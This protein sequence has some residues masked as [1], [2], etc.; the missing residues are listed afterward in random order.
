MDLNSRI[1]L[2]DGNKIPRLGL[3]TW[4]TP[5]G[6]QAENAVSWALEAGYRLVDTAAIYHNEE[7][8]GKAVRESGIPREDVFVTT[9]LWNSDHDAP[10]KA[11]DSSLSR[12]GLEY[13]DLYLMHWPVEGVRNKTWKAMQSLLD[14][15]VCR[16][17][18][19]SNFTVRH[20]VELVEQTGVVPVVNQV[21]FSPFLY[22]RELLDYCKSN[23]IIVEAYSP[24]ARGSRMGDSALTEFTE[25]YGKTPAQILIRWALQHDLV[26]IPK[27]THRERI[28]EN[29]KVFDFSLSQEDMNKLDWLNENYR[30]CWDPSQIP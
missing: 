19:V 30:V 26:V 18:G 21:E 24:L 15:G 2:R 7:S 14:R 27:S 3:G 13:V 16:S 11:F 28:V 17:L 10:L 1:E 29:S 25:K 23:K 12:L 9:K 4:K 5:A 6:Q 20:L 8:V 22:Q